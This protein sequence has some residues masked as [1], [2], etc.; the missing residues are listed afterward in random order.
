MRGS[1]DRP[2]ARLRGWLAPSASTSLQ[3]DLEQSIIDRPTN[4]RVRRKER[5]GRKKR[6][7][8]THVQGNKIAERLGSL[9]RAWTNSSVWI[10]RSAVQLPSLLSCRRRGLMQPPGSIPQLQGHRPSPV[11]SC[12]RGSR[13]S[14]PVDFRSGAVDASPCVGA[15]G[16]GAWRGCG[17]RRGQRA[18]LER[19]L[20]VRPL[21][22][23]LLRQLRGVPSRNRSQSRAQSINSDCRA[24][25]I[26][27]RG[28]SNHGHG[29]ERASTG[30]VL[31]GS[32]CTSP[33]LVGGAPHGQDARA[34][35]SLE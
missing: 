15:Q 4:K 29:V 32:P 24:C 25:N 27:S 34:R 18:S 13:V 19:R 10:Y 33:S 28:Y 7:K 12:Q 17:S 11:P 2:H 16:L 26:P 31:F 9:I 22:G 14:W 20:R 3:K 8:P 1:I 5:K 23:S 30:A 6:K 35:V 21:L